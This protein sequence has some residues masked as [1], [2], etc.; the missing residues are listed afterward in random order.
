MDLRELRLAL[1]RHWLLALAAF[2][3]CFVL[4]LA[5]A[6]LPQK[7][8]ASN[9]TIFVEPIVAGGGGGVSL[10]QQANFVIPGFVERIQSRSIRV[11]AEALVSEPL[12]EVPVGISAQASA[13]VV[14]VRGESHNPEAAA[15]WV[16]ALVS[17]AIAENDAR[18]L[19][20]A[21]VIDPASVPT[22]AFDPRPRPIVLGGAVFGLIAA[23]FAALLAARVTEALD[24]AEAIRRR[25]G[26]TVLGEIP[27]IRQLRRDKQSFT[28]FLGQAPPGLVEAFQGL[29]TNVEFRLAGAVNP[30]IAVVS[31]GPGEGKST[32]VAGLAWAFAAV[33]RRVCVVDANL[34]RPVLHERVGGAMG[35]GLSDLGQEDALNAVQTTAT[36]N[37]EF[38]PA[39]LP[40]GHPAD[41]VAM[42]LPRVLGQLRARNRLVLVD[43]PPVEGVAE[44]AFIV[45]AAGYAVVVVDAGRVE[46]PT[47]TTVVTRIQESGAVLLGV[48]LNRVPARRARKRSVY[49]DRAPRPRPAVP[50]PAA[51]AVADG[52]S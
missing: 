5:A 38:I 12:R 28:E 10:P 9:A 45:G 27:S 33:G 20:R 49:L 4:G 29:R 35:L 37:M 40:A 11:R 18:S 14:R 44:S 51:H 2:G 32:V 7:R 31:F 39:G 23:I 8:Y 13:S 25:L 52:Q 19:I 17:Q 26:T 50:E 34:H 15:E 21:T 3:F 41:V 43:V 47:L 16:N 30:S 46:L 42:T 48:V 22:E 1:R 6:F 36:A 24:S